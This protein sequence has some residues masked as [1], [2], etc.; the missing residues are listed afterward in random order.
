M[1][2]C[3]LEGWPSYRAE[4]WASAAL[5]V[6]GPLFPPLRLGAQDNWC[7]WGQVLWL[8]PSLARQFYQE[9]RSK[10]QRKRWEA[11]NKDSHLFRALLLVYISMQTHL[12]GRALWEGASQVVQ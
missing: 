4:A 11:E 2:E 5:A 7:V 3:P 10:W 8:L 1:A 12:D 6:L 9:V